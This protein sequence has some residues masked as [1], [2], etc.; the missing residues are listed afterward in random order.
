MASTASILAD[1]H[2]GESAAKRQRTGAGAPTGAVRDIKTVGFLGISDYGLGQFKILAERYTVAFATAKR[3]AAA[4][5]SSLDSQLEEL[6]A[7]KGV[8]YLGSVNANSA[9]MIDLASK[10][11]LV[12]IGGYDGIL[13]EPFLKAPRHGVLN[14]HLGMLPLNRGCFPTL[15]AQLHNLPQGFTTY[16]VGTAVDFGPVLELYKADELGGLRD[17]NRS[18]YDTLA[19]KAVDTFADS[20]A[21]FEAGED[22]APCIGCEAYHKKGLPND[23]WLS[24]SWTNIFLRRFS[25][26]L[27]FAPYL[28]GKARVKESGED[29]FL[30]I[31]TTDADGKHGAHAVGAVLE[32]FSDKSP[33]E[34]LVKTREG[35][36]RCQLRKGSLPKQ[37]SILS[38]GRP[39]GDT[40]CEHPIDADFN[41]EELPLERYK[42]VRE[43]LKSP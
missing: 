13:K 9:Q 1:A 32:I 35:T 39:D 10:T 22:L 40:K 43:E 7:K 3:R 23:G 8:T 24:F 2:A 36:A 26:A 14:T 28:P 4:H 41:G 33:A 16:L 11:D 31:E 34:F 17:T 5:A 15:W 6:C 21:R 37:G 42:V 30:S 25:L 19:A 29:I 20:L 38:S 27:D 18:V 12:I